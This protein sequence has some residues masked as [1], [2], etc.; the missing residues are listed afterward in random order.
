MKKIRLIPHAEGRLK[1]YDINKEL[2]VDA[3]NNP[4]EVVRGKR[5]GEIER[6]IAHKLLEDGYMLRVIYEDKNEDTN[7]ITLY[8][9]KLE[10]YYRGGV[11]EN[12]I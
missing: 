5:K 3:I 2:V 10:R 1:R 11:R 8:I 12:K 7:V 6:W 4:D 9:S